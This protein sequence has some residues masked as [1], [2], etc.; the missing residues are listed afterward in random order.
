MIWSN[1]PL[2]KPVYV[3]IGRNHIVLLP[4]RQEE[5]GPLAETDEI[6]V[7]ALSRPTEYRV[8]V[9]RGIAKTI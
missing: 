4:D 1:L 3:V 8:T 6:E 5:L 7:T 2:G 9:H